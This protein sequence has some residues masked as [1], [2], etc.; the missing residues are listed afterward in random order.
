MLSIKY[1]NVI[2]N[3]PITIACTTSPLDTDGRSSVFGGKISK[4]LAVDMLS[5]WDLF[6]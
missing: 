6:S 1:T 2:Y 3:R 5:V 4:M